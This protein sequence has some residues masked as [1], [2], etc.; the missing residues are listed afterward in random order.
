MALRSDSV[1]DALRTI[2]LT[3]LPDVQPA[4]PVRL[5]GVTPMTERLWRA[6]LADIEKNIV[7]HEGVTYFGAG[8]SFG[9][10]V[11]TRDISFA[12][13]LGCNDLYPEVMLSSLK[14]TRVLRK[15]LGFKTS[16]DHTIEDIPAPWE[17][18]NIARREFFLTYHTNEIT[19]RTDDVIWLWAA[20]DL[21]TKLDN[22]EWEWLY[23]EGEWFFE[24]I[25]HYFH[26]SS[27]GLY[28]GQATFVDAHMS[29]T[30]KETG[31]PMDWKL[32]ECI[33]S[34]ATSTNALYYEGM[35]AMARTA[36]RLGKAEDAKRWKEQALQL[37]RAMLQELRHPDGTFGY[38]KTWDG[39]LMNER[40]GLGEALVVRFGIVEGSN[41]RKALEGYPITDAGVPLFYPFFD[42]ADNDEVYHNN[43][44]WPFADAI[45]LA[46]REQAFGEDR[47]AENAALLARTCVKGTFHEVVNMQTKEPFGSGSQLWSA[48]AFID[49][50]RRAILG[51]E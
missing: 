3:D 43:A 4:C 23:E 21:L 35:Q 37:K 33:M 10:K 50:C 6:A 25:Y 2:K 47:T 51:V 31:Y 26:D 45:F 12:G 18:L 7:T 44:S 24:Y 48:A 42:H 38:L 1:T 40:H 49:V 15:R 32:R 14:H 16:R 20:E 11:Y 17:T 27:D 30:H 13:I 9:F 5:S 39:Q 36:Q 46:A 28:R 34:K 41:A 22:P 29:D 8:A 19:R